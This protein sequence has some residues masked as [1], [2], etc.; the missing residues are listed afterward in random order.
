MNLTLVESINEDDQITTY[1]DINFVVS[2]KQAPYFAN[3]KIDYVKGIFG[4]GYF[5]LIRV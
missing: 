3:T 5:K 1:D 2:K 4:N